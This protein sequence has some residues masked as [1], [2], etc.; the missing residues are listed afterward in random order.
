MAST[1]R[2]IHNQYLIGDPQ[3]DKEAAF[4]LGVGDISK[5]RYNDTTYPLS[6]SVQELLRVG[7]S[8]I[9]QPATRWASPREVTT[10]PSLDRFV[11]GEARQVIEAVANCNWSV[12]NKRR[13]N[14]KHSSSVGCSCRRSVPS[15]IQCMISSETRNAN[16]EEQGFHEP[17]SR[18]HFWAQRNMICPVV[19]EE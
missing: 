7:L 3:M 12:I 2:V 14:R 1:E 9:S 11:P 6:I 19:E 18:D 13:L 16:H 8:G 4:H 17:P 5:S 15:G 10:A